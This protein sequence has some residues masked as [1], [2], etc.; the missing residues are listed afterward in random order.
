MTQTVLY[1]AVSIFNYVVLSCVW[2]FN[3]SVIVSLRCL[4]H[5]HTGVISKPGRLLPEVDPTFKVRVSLEL[6]ANALS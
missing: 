2:N 5:L 4:W 6:T 3:K 1:C